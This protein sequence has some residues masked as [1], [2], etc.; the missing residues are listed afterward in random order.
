MRSYDLFSVGQRI[1]IYDLG[2]N[3]PCMGDLSVFPFFIYPAVYFQCMDSYIFILY[4][5]YNTIVFIYSIA[6]F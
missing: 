4:F 6:Y 5:G 2:D 3:I 1:Y